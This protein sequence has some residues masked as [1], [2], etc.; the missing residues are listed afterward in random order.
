MS[1][2]QERC[3]K[4]VPCENLH[5]LSTL[6]GNGQFNIR[7]RVDGGNRATWRLTRA[8]VRRV[9]LASFQNQY[10]A[11]YT[12]PRVDTRPVHSVVRL[13]AAAALRLVA[14]P[15]MPRSGSP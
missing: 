15:R 1:V 3:A 6:L 10:R 8:S 12:N 11:M 14:I 7:K 2:K 4:I 9:F 5:S 13:R